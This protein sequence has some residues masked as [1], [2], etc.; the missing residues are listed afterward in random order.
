[1]SA[2]HS[3]FLFLTI[4]RNTLGQQSVV[5]FVTIV[6]YVMSWGKKDRLPVLFTEMFGLCAPIK[7]TLWWAQGTATPPH[8]QSI[9][10]LQGF[11]EHTQD[12]SI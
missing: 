10:L 2:K 1:M 6:V 9:N 11:T 4:H 8:D 5:R 3:F 12:P 7:Q